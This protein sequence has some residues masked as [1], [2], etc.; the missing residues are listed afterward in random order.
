MRIISILLL[1]VTAIAIAITLWAFGLVAHY[2]YFNDSTRLGYDVPKWHGDT[3]DNSFGYPKGYVFKYSYVRFESGAEPRAIGIILV[4]ATAC[5][6]TIF[7][8]SRGR[9]KA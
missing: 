1:W 3:L 6:G 7:L 4:L 5:A 2:W 8:V 9:K